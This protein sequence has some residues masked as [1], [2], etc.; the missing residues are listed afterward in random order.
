M[1]MLVLSF[2]ALSGLSVISMGGALTGMLGLFLHLFHED[3]VLFR[4]CH[5]TN[6]ALIRNKRPENMNDSESVCTERGVFLWSDDWWRCLRVSLVRKD[7][8]AIS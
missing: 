2:S 6:T 7:M 5:M 8:R 4:Y 3:R 1:S